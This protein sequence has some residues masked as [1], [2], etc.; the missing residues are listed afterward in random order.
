MT[1]LD[2]FGRT[3][4]ATRKPQVL[5]S[6]TCPVELSRRISKYFGGTQMNLVPSDDPRVRLIKNP[7]GVHMTDHVVK[8]A[9]GRWFFINK[10]AVNMDR[11]KE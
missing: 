9:G 5:F 10:S 7:Y 3:T 8:V 11:S 2:P 4:K 1:P 6:D